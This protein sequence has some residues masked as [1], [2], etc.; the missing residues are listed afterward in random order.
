MSLFIAL[1]IGCPLVLFA[2]PTLTGEHDDVMVVRMAGTSP[3]EVFGIGIVGNSGVS[4]QVWVMVVDGD[5]DVMHV[6]FEWGDGTPNG[7]YESAPGFEE[8]TTVYHTWNP[9]PIQGQ[10]DYNVTY[11][12]NVTAYDPDGMSGTTSFTAKI[13]VP[14]NNPP[15]IHINA[16]LKADP[17]DNVTIE[18]YASD[19]E[20][21]PL[22]WTYFFNNTDTDELVLADVRY[23][24]W[25]LPGLAVFNNISR[26]FGVSGNF[27]LIVY[28]SD[29]LPGYQVGIHNATEQSLSILITPNSAPIMGLVWFTPSNLEID[30]KTGYLL[31]SFT[32]ECLDYDKDLMNLTWDFGDGTFAYNESFGIRK[33]IFNQ[34]RNYTEV[35]TYYVNATLTDG[36]AGHELTQN[37]ILRIT[38]NNMPPDLVQ[39]SVSGYGPPNKPPIDFVGEIVHFKAIVTDADHDSIEF[40]WDFGDGSPR[41]FDNVSVYVDQKVTSW[42]NH[43]FT[44]PGNYTITVWYA[45]GVSVTS[46]HSKEYV[47]SYVEVRIDDT[48]PIADAGPNQ[49][50]I[51][52]ALVTFD[53]TGSDDDWGRVNCTWTF[54]YDGALVTLWGTTPAFEFILPGIY[55]VTLNVT[56]HVGN[57]NTTTVTIEVTEVVPEFTSLYPVIVGMMIPMIYYMRRRSRR[58]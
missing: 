43:T 26:V 20:G 57:Y 54:V 14:A 5:G 30:A 13:K 42:V 45:D 29:S 24:G 18:V 7:T 11:D 48:L 44:S 33:A 50:V 10:G 58:E 22:T 55:V 6:E 28:V 27:T 37:L 15:S 16:P 21:E 36:R 8:I 35:G 41:A 51:A 53:G 34:T 23:T 47:F 3:P 46:N 1:M 39:F 2:L 12:V 31:V 17:T 25:T 9:V 32:V 52:P 4:Y 40:A 56:D 38:S 19:A 49:T